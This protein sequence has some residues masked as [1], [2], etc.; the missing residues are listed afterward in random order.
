MSGASIHCLVKIADTTLDVAIDPAFGGQG[1]LPDSRRAARGIAIVAHPHPLFGGTRDNKVV[2]T[3]ARALTAQGFHVLRPNF[4]GVG[5]STGS[6]DEG[7]GES[8][9]LLALYDLCAQAT[10]PAWWPDIQSFEAKPEANFMWP[11][12]ADRVLAGFSFGAFVQTLVAQNTKS[13]APVLALV[14]LAVSRF[15][16]ALVRE[17]ALVV[18]GE[19]D[20]V[21]ALA[22]VLNWARPQAQA[23]VVVPGAGHFF[24]GHLTGLKSIVTDFLL[25]RYNTDSR[26]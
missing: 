19:Q 8:K 23:V 22:D 20:D 9:D 24:H 7:Q 16:A 10:P 18:H 21:V 2:M 13:I 12:G 4:R 14:G 1:F 6:F 11:A 3:L 15:P 26:K 5:E 17:G 25:A